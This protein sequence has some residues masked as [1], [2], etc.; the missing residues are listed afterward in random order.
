MFPKPG[1]KA[2]A[3]CRAYSTPVHTLPDHFFI[4][5][6]ISLPSNLPS[7]T[8]HVIFHLATSV[9]LSCPGVVSAIP[10][11]RPPTPAGRSRC[12]LLFSRSSFS[13]LKILPA[14]IL[15]VNDIIPPLPTELHWVEISASAHISAG[16]SAPTPLTTVK[17][18]RHPDTQIMRHLPA[19][20]GRHGH[21]LARV[22]DAEMLWWINFD[23]RDS[24]TS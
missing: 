7:I 24:W 13:A 3:S 19:F 1:T 11:T 9:S 17:I 6:K 22:V 21:F 23:N 16:L 15:L 20:G 8:V 10:L 14:R 18:R 4:R 2:L 5:Y 12:P